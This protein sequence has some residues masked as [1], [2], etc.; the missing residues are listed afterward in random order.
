M[1]TVHAT[2]DTAAPGRAKRP[3]LGRLTAMELRKMTDT[4]AGAWLLAIVTLIAVGMVVLQLFTGD[5]GGRTFAGVFAG[6]LMPVSILLPVLGI[7]SVTSEWSQR[8]VVT[9][10]TLVPV[11][12]R[13]TAAK[14]LA[15]AVLAAMSV[16][17]CLA[18]AA[19]GN[20][21]V[22]PFVDGDGG[23]AIEPVAIGNAFVAQLISV[24]MGMAF[25]MLFMS[26]PLAIVLYFL[27]P[28]VWATL[29]R[30]VDALATAREWLDQSVTLAALTTG[31]MTGE[32]W[33]KVAATAG[34]WLL[35]PLAAGLVRLMRREVS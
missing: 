30:F 6:T 7:L 22:G 13:T 18:V 28:A 10:F 1:S 4:R 26:T 33:A 24:L 17:V 9:T 16:V 14:L 15:G 27:L 32:S 35:L 21:L 31:E 3:S 20:L 11:R 5:G 19:A 29:G 25:G 8:T 23:W 34:V 12:W 2:T